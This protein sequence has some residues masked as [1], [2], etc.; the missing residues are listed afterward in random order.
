MDMLTFCVSVFK[1][2]RRH[3]RPTE[4]REAT[5]GMTLLALCGTEVL[6]DIDG[7]V[8]ADAL[9]LSSMCARCAEGARVLHR[10]LQGRIGAV[11][12]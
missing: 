5:G 9:E 6:Y 11:E 3:I 1:D 12:N 10:Q 4:Q 8:T 7:A 2:S